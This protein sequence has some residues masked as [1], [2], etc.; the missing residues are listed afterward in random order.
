MFAL[1]DLKSQQRSKYRSE[2]P[3]ASP[4]AFSAGAHSNSGQSSS[5]SPSQVTQPDV[6]EDEYDLMEEAL[7][8]ALRRVDGELREIS[9]N[10]TTMFST[11][12][13]R[14]GCDSRLIDYGTT[15]NCLVSD[16]EHIVVLNVGD[17]RC[18]LVEGFHD[19]ANGQ[20]WKWTHRAVSSDHNP[21]LRQDEVDRVCGDNGK[22]H[23]QGQEMR[24]FPKGLSF[25]EARRKGLAINMSRAVGHSTL[26]NHGLVAEPEVYRIAVEEDHE[27]IFVM[28]SDGVW[29]V[30]GNGEVFDVVQQICS[31]SMHDQT[32]TT[33]EEEIAVEVMETAEKKWSKKRVGDNVSVVVTRIV[34]RN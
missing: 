3:R 33:V 9:R 4:R 12:L 26:C 1:H 28:A 5:A 31:S 10:E 16:G 11:I 21:V 6:V 22:F 20:K 24:L 7:R 29:D 2:S 18:I 27:Y 8:I 34:G 17:S 19:D 15:V 14:N 13:T 32:E 25:K 30:M 23:V